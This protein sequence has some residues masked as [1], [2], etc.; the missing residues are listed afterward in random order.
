MSKSAL[1]S[2]V[3]GVILGAAPTTRALE[4]PAPMPA[5][6]AW[7][8]YEQADSFQALHGTCAAPSKSIR[9]QLYGFVADP[10]DCSVSQTN[11]SEEYIPDEVWEVPVV[12]Q[13]L[14]DSS[15]TQAGLSD[16]VIQ[17]QLEVVNEDF[18]AIFGTGGEFGN[19]SRIDFVLASVDPAGNPT[20]GVVRTCNSD[21]FEDQGEYWN[22]LAWD[23]HRYLNIYTVEANFG[24]YVPFF[25]ADSGGALVGT[26]EDR[27]VVT[28]R[29]VGR[30]PWAGAPND[31]G[32]T[33]VHEIGHYLGLE[34]DGHRGDSDRRRS[35]RCRRRALRS[36][37]AQR[38]DGRVSS[39]RSS[40]ERSVVA[41][42][43]DLLTHCSQRAKVRSRHAL[44]GQ[45]FQC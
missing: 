22:E 28:W 17:S 41:I 40:D 29:V 23:P 3:I 44:S 27:V 37:G 26:A 45:T 21:W 25:P 39:G 20:T 24:G 43:R 42:R 36:A 5:L 13:V 12:F 7:S 35:G 34:D 8:G 1:S 30:D 14:Q 31:G 4:A 38:E 2:L 15:C 19:D 10:S 18:R 33:L 6:E 32:R 11:P 9:E 16:E